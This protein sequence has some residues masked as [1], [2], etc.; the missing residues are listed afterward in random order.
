MVRIIRFPL[1]LL[2]SEAV[3]V[4]GPPSVHGGALSFRGASPGEET[5]GKSGPRTLNMPYPSG[6]GLAP[7][8]DGIIRSFVG[9][10][11]EK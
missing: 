10:F 1:N 11:H 5:V 7:A 2:Y 9:G 4:F 3:R 6:A 8:L